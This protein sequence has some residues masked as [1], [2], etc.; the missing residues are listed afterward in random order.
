MP[1]FDIVSE[2]D[3]HE[4][5]NAVDQATREIGTRF[6]FRKVK[7]ATFELSES[8]IKLTADSAFQL[9]QMLDV[10]KGKLVGRKIDIKCLEMGGVNAGGVKAFQIAT[11][12]VGLEQP[13]A[14]KIVKLI[15]EKKLKVQAAIQ[16]D[17]V[18]I[19][20]KKRD[21]LQ[22]VMAMLREADIDVPLQFTNFRD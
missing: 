7:D 5:T 13:N 18:R 4:V 2:L 3:M 9:Q 8:E 19:T 11:L 22:G 17:Q 15:K 6:D 16:G 20:G 10:L 14:K 1:S 21:D 12:K